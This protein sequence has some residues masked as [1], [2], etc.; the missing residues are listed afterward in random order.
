MTDVST[1]PPFV[2]FQRPVFRFR[3]PAA[4]GSGGNGAMGVTR[5]YIDEVANDVVVF[6]MAGQ[7]VCF[8]QLRLREGKEEEDGATQPASAAAA[9]DDGDDDDDVAWMRHHPTLPADAV[10]LAV[11]RSG[12]DDEPL[13]IRYAKRCPIPLHSRSSN[14]ATPTQGSG[15][16]RAYLVALSVD[17]RSIL[18]VVCRDG[19][20]ALPLCAV[21]SF[22]CAPRSLRFRDDFYP[23]QAYYWA[24]ELHD[25]HNSF[26]R[27]AGPHGSPMAAPPR[28]QRESQDGSSSRLPPVNFVSSA[29]SSCRRVLLC[30]TT[31]SLDVVGVEEALLPCGTDDTRGRKEQLCVLLRRFP[32]HT[33]YWHYCPPA[34]AF[35]SI[36][37]LKPHV[38]KTFEV[39]EN[40]LRPLPELRLPEGDASCGGDRDRDTVGEEQRETVSL[41]VSPA[42]MDKP[43]V[44]Y[45]VGLLVLYRQ[46]FLCSVSHHDGGATLFRYL[47]A[48]SGSEEGFV[49]HALLRAEFP[50]NP[51]REPVALQVVDN[52]IILHALRHGFSCAF[53]IVSGGEEQGL[54]RMFAGA[55]SEAVTTEIA[56]FTVT[57][58]TTAAA[59]S[60]TR[61]SQHGTAAVS[62]QSIGGGNRGLCRRLSVKVERPASWMTRL[63]SELRGSDGHSS[64]SDGCRCRSRNN[65]SGLPLRNPLLSATLM[66]HP[67]LYTNS[68]T[69]VHSN[70]LYSHAFVYGTLPLLLDRHRGSVHLVGVNPFA[71]AATMPH[72]LQRVRFYLRRLHCAG[73]AVQSLL[74]TMLSRQECL[75]CVAHALEA[76]ATHHATQ[77]LLQTAQEDNEKKKSRTSSW[78]RD[79]SCLGVVSANLPHARDDAC[80]LGSTAALRQFL[81]AEDAEGP[82]PRAP[83]WR[84][85]GGVTLQDVLDTCTT[86]STGVRA[87]SGANDCPVV[88]V[89]DVSLGQLVMQRAVFAPLVEVVL[90]PPP[91]AAGHGDVRVKPTGENVEQTTTA[92]T[93]SAAAG[94]EDDAR[95]S[96]E[97]CSSLGRVHFARYLFYALFEYASCVMRTG[98]VLLD[99]LQRLLLRLLQAAELDCGPLH[100]LLVPGIITD[101]VLTAMVLLSMGGAYRKLG[102]DMLLRLREDALVVQVLLTERRP[103]DAARYIYASHQRSQPLGERL[104]NPRMM[105]DVLQCALEAVLDEERQRE[106]DSGSGG[107]RRRS[108][109][110]LTV[111]A[112]FTN[113]LMQQPQ[114]ERSLPPDYH[115]MR[116]K[117]TQLLAE[118]QS[119]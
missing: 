85:W 73:D 28:E 89:A 39:D 60:A 79:P 6:C 54:Q 24:E 97:G 47:S 2:V 103:L 52:L 32:T 99:G 119:G 107:S 110:F 57:T 108:V 41:F 102:I 3:V 31:I 90:V 67:P 80:F 68:S 105:N 117:Y 51:R 29:S 66:P 113:A 1:V 37:R 69:T 16:S 59:A 18:F 72:T 20:G 98:S 9:A 14:M 7:Q 27:S 46:L 61:G 71:F 22:Q 87:A 112:I 86:L 64:A 92:T 118:A 45:P 94:D 11:K 104:L 19:T 49:L 95:V 82:L 13:S 106:E 40:G 109:E 30:I 111:F 63:A 70:E 56:S 34:R 65:D 115:V 55:A 93:L 84:S 5:V 58:T 33:D 77:Q 75:N 91:T 10:A 36:N 50:L 25:A 88:P 116:A 62:S 43:R 15:G 21:A 48:G 8:Y 4:G 26:C 17:T 12:G 78:T 114:A 74:H 101:H 81:P 76:I 96:N 38:L 83:P 35:L 53:D 42:C 23:I 100:Q 44:Q